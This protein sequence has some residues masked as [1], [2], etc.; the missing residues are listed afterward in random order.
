MTFAPKSSTRRRPLT[1]AD[2]LHGYSGFVTWKRRVLLWRLRLQALL[3]PSRA[4]A[5]DIAKERETNSQLITRLASIAGLGAVFALVLTMVKLIIGSGGN[6]VYLAAVL[7]RISL[8]GLA[9]MTL[10]TIAASLIPIA[11][12]LAAGTLAGS[13]ATKNGQ[14]FSAGALVLILVLFSRVI[15]NYVWILALTLYL[16]GRVVHFKSRRKR[17]AT[18]KLPG[19]VEWGRMNRWNR[20]TI[21]RLLA[22]RARQSAQL[23][24]EER[25]ALTQEIS[26]RVELLRLPPDIAKLVGVW[27]AISGYAF[28]LLLTAPTYSALYLVQ[29]SEGDQVAYMLRSDY[30][31][32]LI[33]SLNRTPKV[34]QPS[35]IVSWRLCGPST[36]DLPWIAQPMVPPRSDGNAAC[37]A[38]S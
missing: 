16:I 21:I 36:S 6:T 12:F 5:R 20:D 4:A 9:T 28:S 3:F 37:K 18:P 10:A 1:Q 32:L 15:P 33:D 29:T 35:Q 23:T 13:G 14:A 11:I 30:D 34:W 38:G 22:K 17:P 24:K 25:R 7:E 31:V 19:L 26:D 8:S 27:A 2:E